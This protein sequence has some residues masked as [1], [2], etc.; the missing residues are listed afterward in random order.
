MVP[1]ASKRFEGEGKPNN[2]NCLCTEPSQPPKKGSQKTLGNPARTSPEAL[3]RFEGATENN[4]RRGQPGKSDLSK[5]VLYGILGYVWNLY[6]A[7]TQ[8]SFQDHPQKT[9]QGTQKRGP[10]IT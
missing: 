8:V 10:N 7:Q 5:D 2:P 1:N 4:L 3:T 9:F 6:R